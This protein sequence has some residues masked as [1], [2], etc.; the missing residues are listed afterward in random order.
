M[1]SCNQC[2]STLPPGAKFCPDCGTTAAA[3]RCTGCHEQIAADAEFCTHCGASAGMTEQ[4][5]E[6]MEAARDAYRAGDLETLTGLLESIRPDAPG[7]LKVAEWHG[8]LQAKVRF[9]EREGFRRKIH[10]AIADSDTMTLEALQVEAEADPELAQLAAYM[11]EQERVRLERERAAGPDPELELEW[12]WY[13]TVFLLSCVPFPL[14]FSMVGMMAKVQRGR[15]NPVKA[16]SLRRY[17]LFTSSAV[18]VLQI[19]VLVTWVIR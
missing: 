12:G 19:I 2:P 9:E 18:A 1:L 4:H 6:K 7:A 13:L 3:R 5:R 8:E 14:G 16:R 15:W 17:A 11:L 10:S